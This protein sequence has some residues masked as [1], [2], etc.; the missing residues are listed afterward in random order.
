MDINAAFPSKY[1]KASDLQ[2]KARNVVI[3]TVTMEVVDT[4]TQ[5]QKPCVYFQDKQKGLVLNVTNGNAIQDAY[6]PE[7][8]AWAGKPIQLYPTTT[9]F[10]GK[11]VACIRVRVARAKPVPPQQVED[12]PLDE[13]A[14]DD[15]IPF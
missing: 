11:T 7:T 8:A 13:E 1:M 4:R 10:S 5:E 12:F 2:G 6:G 14:P 3:S 15:N 9:E